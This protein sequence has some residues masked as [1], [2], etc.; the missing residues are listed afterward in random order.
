MTNTV[1]RAPDGDFPHAALAEA[2]NELV[3]ALRIK[4]LLQ[5]FTTAIQ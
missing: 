1:T 5:L 4:L 3:A 2:T